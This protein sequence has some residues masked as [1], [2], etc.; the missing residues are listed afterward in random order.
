MAKQAKFI[1]TESVFPRLP[2][3]FDV[4]IRKSQNITCSGNLFDIMTYVLNKLETII[5]CYESKEGYS[6]ENVP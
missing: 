1:N 2:K 3:A 4:F 5:E 6:T